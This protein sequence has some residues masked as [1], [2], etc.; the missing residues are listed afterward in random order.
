MC[1]QP[2]P[3]HVRTALDAEDGEGNCDR[4]LE[5]I[6][7]SAEILTFHLTVDF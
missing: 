6:P 4:P 5:A 7:K 1:E 3:S 2:D